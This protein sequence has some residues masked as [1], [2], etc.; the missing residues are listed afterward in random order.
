MYR[1]Q[2]DHAAMLNSWLFL[3]LTSLDDSVC[4][5]VSNSKKIATIQVLI[6]VIYVCTVIPSF[7]SS[8]LIS[9]DFGACCMLQPRCHMNDC[10]DSSQPH[11]I[12]ICAKVSLGCSKDVVLSIGL[13]N[14]QPST[15]VHVKFE[16][17]AIGH[18]YQMI[19]NA[20]E[21]IPSCQTLLIVS[22]VCSQSSL[23]HSD[24]AADF[25]DWPWCWSRSDSTTGLENRCQGFHTLTPREL[26][27]KDIERCCGQVCCLWLT[28]TGP[29]HA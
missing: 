21:I 23:P 26:R 24:I 5:S 6:Y 8:L 14:L 27:R 16:E 13:P 3:C 9:N 2:Q 15:Q 12:G 22:N 20:S 19:S 25:S 18:G 10:T 29:Q 17:A 28:K 7:Q 11:A 1:H 4:A